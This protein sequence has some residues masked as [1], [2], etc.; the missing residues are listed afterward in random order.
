MDAMIPTC[1]NCGFP[2]DDPILDANNE[3]WC[4]FCFSSQ[5][6]SRPAPQ[7]NGLRSYQREAHSEVFRV[8]LD[9]G[10]RSTLVV[11]PTGTGKTVL[12]GQV[13]A[14]W[15]NGRV[16]IVAHRD[17]LIRQAADKVGKIVGEQCDIEMGDDYADQCNLYSRAHVVVTSVQTM[18]RERRMQRFDPNDFG[19]VIIDEAHH[20]VASTYRKVIDYFSQNPK[21]KIFGVTATPD[22]ADEEALGKVFD[23]VAFEYAITQAIEDAW[24]VPI[25]QQFVYV[26]GLDFSE[27]RTTAGD[28]NAGDLAKVMEAEE[29]LHRVVDP[30]IRLA[31]DRPCLVFAASVAHADR[32]AEICNRHKPNSAEMIH[33]GTD[34]ELRRDILRRF[35][36]GEFQF[37]FNCM[38]A[39]EGFDEPQIGVVAIARPTKS[40]ALYAQMIGRGTRPLTGCVD[41][42]MSVE[43]RQM[44]IR[45]SPKPAVTIL[46]FVGNSG[47][48][49][50]ISTADILGGNMNDDVVERAKSKA[51]KKSAKGEASDMTAEL[52]EAQQEIENEARR[53]RAAIVAKAQFGTKAVDPFLLYDVTPQREP[54]YFK[55]KRPS[56]AMA[57]LLERRG[58]DTRNMSFW[59]AKQLIPVVKA[60][61]SVKQMNLL[62]KFGYNAD[63][64]A[65]EAKSIIDKLAAN[66]WRRPTE[67]THAG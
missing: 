63:V 48:H 3:P 29:I 16:L 54:G 59:E 37:L 35:N 56:E 52:I 27:M 1:T 21:L 15:P 7:P 45:M 47:K 36:R 58:V 61:P 53:K 44:A 11:M 2:V 39:T 19:V 33:G 60:K 51:A 13:A 14:D 8:L 55:G 42:T 12:F 30:T 34:R 6:A 50:L 32:M 57:Q 65:I 40:R 31:G 26:E 28:L 66:G 20:A 49:K 62:R 5:P 17:E 9:D 38:I 23:S 64:T 41:D 67:V 46:D 25:E 22:R 43:E 18:S 24:L 4:S 10:N